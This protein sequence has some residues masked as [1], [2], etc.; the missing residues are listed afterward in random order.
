MRDRGVGRQVVDDELAQALCVALGDPDEVVGRPGE[1]EDA[2]H[3]GQ[4]ADWRV[5]VSICSRAWTARRTATMACSGR[6]SCARSTSAWKPRS[7][8][9]GAQRADPR[10]ARGGRDAGALGQ[11]RV[12]QARVLGQG[13]D[14][15]A[16]DVVQVDWPGAA[17]CSP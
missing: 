14:E 4:A 6:P 3:A 10:N 15:P 9:A 12:G 2:E 7:D 8:A 5:K 11:A 1:V 13:L 17:G 16:V